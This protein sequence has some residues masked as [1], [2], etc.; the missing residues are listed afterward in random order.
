MKTKT[1]YRVFDWD[2]DGEEEIF[3]T[4]GQAEHYYNQM[5]ENDPEGNWRLYEDKELVNGNFIEDCL[6]CN[7]KD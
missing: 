4:Y 6:L 5:I 7:R 1:A 3:D 2:S